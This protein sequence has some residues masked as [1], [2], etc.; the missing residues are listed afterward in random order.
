MGNLTH[1]DQFGRVHG[2]IEVLGEIIPIDCY[3]MRDR[4]WGPRPEHRPRKSAYVTGI[5]S[6][7]ES[8][9]AVPRSGEHCNDVAYGFLIREGEIGD[10]VSGR[11]SIERDPEQGWVNRIVIDAVDEHGRKLH[12]E[13]KRI[14]GITLVRHSFIDNNGLI[15]WS[16]DGKTGHGED[17]DMWPVHDWADYRRTGVD[18]G[19]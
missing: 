16:I 19:A 18:I 15:E 12:A 5:A 1:F 2:T 14:S 8:F 9:L 6:P 3:G 7:E 11:R 13:G 17:Q 10:L 4:S